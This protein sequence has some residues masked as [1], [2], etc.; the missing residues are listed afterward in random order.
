MTG[1]MTT[2]TLV[3]TALGRGSFSPAE[4]GRLD[5][6]GEVDF[7]PCSAPLTEERFVELSRP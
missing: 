3:I 4:L 5:G 1:H 6:L 2:R 7:E